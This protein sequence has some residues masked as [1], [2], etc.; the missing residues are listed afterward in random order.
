MHI[1]DGYLSPSTCVCMLGAAAPFWLVALNRVKRML[2]TRMIPLLALFAAFAFVIMMFNLPLPGGTTGHAVGMGVASIVLGPWASMLAISVALVIQAVFFGDGGITTIGANCFNMAIVGSLV[3]YG[4]YRVLGRGAFI[5]SRRRVLAAGIAGYAAIN[6]AALCAAIE[7]GIQPLFFHDASGAPLYAP[8]SLSISIPAMLI[9]HLSF[10]GLAELVI[11]S[12]L[13]AWLQKVDP[14]LLRLT[15]PDAP[16]FDNPAPPRQDRLLWPAAWKLWLGLGILLVLTPLGILAVGTAWG[17]WSPADF[18]PGQVPHGLA[19][20][21]SLWTAPLSRYAPSFIH[22]PSLGYLVSAIVGVGLI[23]VLSL[24]L[25]RAVSY[26]AATVR[27]PVAGRR[28]RENF[29]DKTIRSLLRVLRQA[30]FA[31][32]TAQSP[33]LLQRL[34]A[35]V[36]VAG[37]LLLIFA[38]LGLHRL[39]VLAGLLAAC[40]VLA[41]VSRIPIRVLAAKVWIAVLAFT[42]AIAIP[43]IFLTSGD[44]LFRVPVLDWAASSQGLRSAA[45]LILRAETAA[46]L[47]ALLVLCTLWPLLLRALRWFRVPGVLVT[48]VGMTYRYLFLL[49]QT[50]EEMFEAREARLIGVLQPADRRRLAAASAGLLLSKSIQLSGEVHLAMQAR[51]FRGDVRL[52][53]EPILEPKD[54]IA[55]AAFASAAG[56]ALWF[57]R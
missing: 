6:V 30:L 50:A 23:I 41:L 51:G 28:R 14:S 15:G 24:P 44:V 21:S 2:N 45:F 11:S 42:G 4:A 32:E 52:L 13:V 17:E 34:D 56:A 5:G 10:A 35:R 27:E 25:Y 9:G 20:F 1:P 16:D 54:W 18:S 37:I 36:K 33:G 47:A 39:S 12:G 38:A 55:L 53:D 29:V 43:A 7:F 46:T 3:S 48:I 31:E 8:Y 26:R 19:R 22:S 57:G 49:A 40:V